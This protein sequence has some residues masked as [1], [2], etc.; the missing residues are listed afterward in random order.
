MFWLTLNVKFTHICIINLCISFCNSLP[1]VYTSTKL[2]NL[3]QFRYKC[4]KK[5]KIMNTIRTLLAHFLFHFHLMANWNSQKYKNLFSF[6]FMFIYWRLAVQLK[7]WKLH[8]VLKF[9]IEYLFE[10]IT[11]ISFNR[12]KTAYLCKSLF[13]LI[14]KYNNT[15]NCLIFIQ[16]PPMP[17]LLDLFSFWTKGPWLLN[18]VIIYEH[19]NRNTVQRI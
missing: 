6:Y 19:T 4:F 9:G 16:P 14:W 8:E 10:K 17:K 1:L 3:Y 13:L 11:T 2:I 12:R 15:Q 7:V 18:I 5:L